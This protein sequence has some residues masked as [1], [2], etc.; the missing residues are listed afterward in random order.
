MS[1]YLSDACEVDGHNAE[2][3]HDELRTIRNALVE[4]VENAQS[5]TEPSENRLCLTN[6]ESMIFLEFF[7]MAHAIIERQS[8]FLLKSEIIHHEYYGH[9]VTEALV[10]RQLTQSQREKFLHDCGVISD[11]LKGEMKKVRQ[12]RNDLAHNY[13]ERLSVREPH[14]VKNKANAAIRILEELEQKVENRVR[15]PDP[16]SYN[17][18]S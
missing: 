14:Q 3:I 18:P 9:E 6:Q 13:D 4:A 17:H 16:E 2:S 5:R 11:G 12:K 7:T 15:E 1:D 10:K 8:I